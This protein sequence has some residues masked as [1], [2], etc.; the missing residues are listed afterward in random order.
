YVTAKH[1]LLAIAAIAAFGLGYQLSQSTGHIPRATP[2][3]VHRVV[4]Y[5]F[6]L[7]TL[8]TLV[9]YAAWLGIALRNGLTLDMLREFFTTDDPQVWETLSKEVFVNWKGVTTAS[10]F[11]VAAVPLGVWLYFQGQ[12]VLVWPLILLLALAAVRAVAF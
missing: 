3:R 6:W 12:R 8:L 4:R 7:T 2:R 9:G 11:S 5:A 1:V 10:Q